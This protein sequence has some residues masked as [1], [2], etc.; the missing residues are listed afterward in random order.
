M[1]IFIQNR[2][3]GVVVVV[4]VLFLAGRWESLEAIGVARLPVPGIFIR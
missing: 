2:V 4:V 3:V 1:D